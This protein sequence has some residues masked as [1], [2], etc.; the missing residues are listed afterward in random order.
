MEVSLL[1]RL[2][3]VALLRVDY[4][5]PHLEASRASKVRRLCV[6]PK[7]ITEVPP[8]PYTTPCQRIRECFPGIR[9]SKRQSAHIT[10]VVS[11][12]LLPQPEVLQACAAATAQDEE[13]AWK[14]CFDMGVVL[15]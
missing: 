5:S 4:S 7:H 13:A 12:A 6:V 10:N 11:P 1:V 15:A 3:V 2:F 14:R 9:D 8:H